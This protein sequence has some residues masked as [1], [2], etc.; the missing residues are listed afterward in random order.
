M[1]RRLANTSDSLE[2]KDYT[3]MVDR[4]NQVL[5]TVATGELRQEGSSQQEL[6][7]GEIK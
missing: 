1:I 5:S 4:Y 2:D 6:R 7:D 3:S